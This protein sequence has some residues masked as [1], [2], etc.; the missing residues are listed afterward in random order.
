ML[1][2]SVGG[3]LI[4]GLLR[5]LWHPMFRVP[6]SNQKGPFWAFAL[7]LRG[8][9]VIM[10]AIYFGSRASVLLCMLFHG[11]ANASFGTISLP[12]EA[13]RNAFLFYLVASTLMLPWFPTP[14]FILKL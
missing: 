4:L 9:S 10:T 2:G 11:A 8:W 3:T 1:G 13:E 12:A 6:G 5:A 14:L 7:E